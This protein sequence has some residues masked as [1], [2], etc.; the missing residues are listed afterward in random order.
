MA[1][2]H[3][4]EPRFTFAV[5][6][7]N[8]ST[9]LAGMVGLAQQ[10]ARPGDRVWFVDSASRD[11]SIA[12]ARRLGVEVIEAPI[13]KG[14]AMAAVVDQCDT[15]YIC[16]L[17]ADWF[18]WTVEVPAVL[19]AEAISTGAGMVVGAYVDDRRRLIQPYVYWPLV[20]AL[21]PDYGRLCDPTPLSG[22]RVIDPALVRKP[23]PLGYGVETYLN[24]TFASVGHEIA[25]V[26]LGALRGPLRDYGNVQEVGLVAATEILDFAV[27]CGRLDRAQRPAWD[28]WVARV[29]EAIGLPPLPG[30]PDEAYLAAVAATAAHPLPQARVLEPEVT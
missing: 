10:A 29:L 14:R 15:D 17:D 8:E 24:L 9:R 1:P 3:P 23:L 21:F 13:G 12:V 19:R 30:E 4:T 5:V 18:E 11:D 26:D 16:F 27:G 25:V 28:L 2:V 7:R 6:G 22:M 20:D